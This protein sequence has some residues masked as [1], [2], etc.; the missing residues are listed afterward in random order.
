MG[1]EDSKCLTSD[2]YHRFLILK[3]LTSDLFHE[4]RA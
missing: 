4:G 3:Y 1:N 2:R